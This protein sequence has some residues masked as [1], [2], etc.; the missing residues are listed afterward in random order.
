[1]PPPYTAL[2]STP[3][4][5]VTVMQP[6]ARTGEGLQAPLRYLAVRTCRAV[7]PSGGGLSK[8]AW[9]SGESGGFREGFFF[10]V[11]CAMMGWL[12]VFAHLLS[13]CLQG[14]R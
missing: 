10:A 7:Y 2:R 1:M 12:V 14:I 8:P 6:M 4:G 13:A 3:E 9:I 11:D 5:A